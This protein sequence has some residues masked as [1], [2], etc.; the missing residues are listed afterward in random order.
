MNKIKKIALAVAAVSAASAHG[1]EFNAGPI[2]GQLNT[3]LSYGVA[4]R[5]E[6]PN[7]RVIAP[8]NTLVSDGEGSTS[9]YDD[10]TLNYEKGDAYTNVVKGSFDL[11]LDYQGMVGAFVRGKA[12][13][14]SAIMDTDPK[15]KEYSDETKDA[16]GSGYDLLDAFVWYN[17]EIGDTP[18]SARAGRQVLSWGESTFIR[19]SINA[20]NP[21]DASA[22]RKPGVEV[23]EVLLPVNLAYTSLGLTD[24]LT[25]EAFY[26]LQW[27]KTRAD[28]CGTFFSTVDFATD[29][30]GQVY[31]SSDT[32]EQSIQ[33]AKDAG[34]P[35]TPVADRLPDQ[36]PKNDGQYGFALRW[37]SEALGDTEFGLY[38][39]NIHSRT[40]LIAGKVS[41]QASGDPDLRWP[42]YYFVYPE[43][44][45][46]SAISFNRATDSGWSIGGE[47]SLK[48]D[49]PVSWNAFEIL[50]AG[51]ESDL[52]L[53]YKARVAEYMAANGV[54]EGT[55]QTALAGNVAEGWDYYDVWQ[56]QMTFIKFFDQVMGA[57][58][59]NFVSEVG[60]SYI[61]DL[62]DLDEA[63]YGRS[64]AFGIGTVPQ[65]DGT[66]RCETDALAN[67]NAD[68]CTNDGYTDEWS[69]GIRVR[70]ILEYPNAFA[71]VNL[72]PVLALGYD[73]GTSYQPGPFV[74]QRV[75][76]SLGLDF[77]YLNQ[78]SG[79]VSYTMYD[80][81][82]YDDLKD[83]DNVSLNLKV[84]F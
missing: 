24:T 69:G 67:K 76:A 32:S 22:A 55:A 27:E 15:F 77:D 33:A 83:R 18:V 20:I 45:Q 26:Q 17:F 59:L 44:L 62:P 13:Y 64:G 4:W 37:Y 21:I 7:K 51:V 71:G 38:H 16:A 40:P 8:N 78:Y 58:R 50:M 73:M 30:C 75:S 46:M 74:D 66:D 29:G 12:F 9:N 39:M 61:Q 49:Y 70:T 48:Q 25:L 41:N 28:A 52:S 42:D 3:S 63:R 60:V 82:E 11:E 1:V 84:S 14:D 34:V 65:D 31:L 2:S 19:G 56:A 54:D 79:G 80:G 35:A 43:N 47:I 57:S 53:L 5:T 23:K 81:N 10:G 6:E 36:Q 68:N 72:K